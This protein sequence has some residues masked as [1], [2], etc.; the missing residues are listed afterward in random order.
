MR[1]FKSEQLTPNEVQVSLKTDH[2]GSDWILFDVFV[3]QNG[4]E[5]GHIK[6]QVDIWGSK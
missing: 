2:I 5:F 1:C 3:N 4:C 6:F